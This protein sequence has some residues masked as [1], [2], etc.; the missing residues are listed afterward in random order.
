M[1]SNRLC[2][3]LKFAILFRCRTY[4]KETDCFPNIIIADTRETRLETGHMEKALRDETVNL[5]KIL[6]GKPIKVLWWKSCDV[7]S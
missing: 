4:R 3:D 6:S 1:Q 5:I 2:K 7:F